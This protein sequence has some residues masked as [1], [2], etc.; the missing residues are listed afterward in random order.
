MPRK[1]SFCSAFLAV[2]F[3][4]TLISTL[5]PLAQAQTITLKKRKQ[6][7]SGQRAIVFDDQLAALRTQPNLKAP[8]IQ[9]LRYGRVVGIRSSVRK[10][11]DG[12]RFFLVSIS[13]N[14]SGWLLADA[15]IRPRHPDD[16][17]RL[18]KLLG[19]TDD[20][21]ARMRLA[22]LCA[23]EF[24]GLPVAQQA[25]LTLA[26]AAEQAAVR[27]SREAQRRIAGVIE[28]AGS[29]INQREYA[30]NYSGLDRYNRIG[31]TFDYDQSQQRFVYDG[32]AYRELLRYYPRSTNAQQ[33]RE[34]LAKLKE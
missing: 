10:G 29:S 6:L 22:R 28:N 3:T 12:M 31:V 1:K 23:D 16:A 17:A 9:R 27:L 20:L 5:A 11:P 24:R 33:V 34:R 7:I 4:A 8:L 26:E 2:C 18:S 25:L 15:V 30:L 14:T 19:E 13:R 21:Y 32:A